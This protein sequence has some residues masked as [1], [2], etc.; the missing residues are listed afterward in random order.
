[1]GVAIEVVDPRGRE[2][3]A[4]DVLRAAWPLPR[5]RY[6]ADDLAWQFGRPG[7]GP[8]RG[9]A[10]RDGSGRVVAFAA[11]VARSVRHAGAVREVWLSSF[12]AAR[13]GEP[14]AALT[15]LRTQSLDLKATGRPTVVFATPGS[16][17]EAMLRCNDAVGFT[18]RPLAVGRVH[19]GIGGPADGLPAVTE[20]TAADGAELAAFLA[21]RP[22]DR[23]IRDAPDPAALAHDALDPRGRCWAVVRDV[24]GRITAAA[25]THLSRSEVAEGPSAVATLSAVSLPPGDDGGPLAALVGFAAR[26]WADRVTSPVVTLPNPAGI[27][28]AAL[29]SARLR[30]LPVSWAPFVFCPDPADPLLAA[31]ATDLEVI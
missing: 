14:G 31:E 17:G 25:C 2:A 30:A 20:A 21:S 26:R 6:A 4:A 23:V 24:A 3:E 15:L 7:W 1:M 13:P 8:P 27:P 22:A 18:R 9:W 5:L 16:A 28:P 29:R 12:Y 11:S 10:A 19:G